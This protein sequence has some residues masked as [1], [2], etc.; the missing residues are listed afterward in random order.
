MVGLSDLPGG[1][2][3]SVAL[4]VTNDGAT[5]VGNST[6]AN[7]IEAFRWS[8]ATGIAALGDL[9]GGPFESSARSIASVNRAIV[10]Y[11]YSDLGQEAV[12]WMPSQ[13]IKSLRDVLTTGGV[14]LAGWHLQI[15]TGISAD[16]RVI[17]GTGINPS[18]KTE[19]WLA[20][21]VP[22]PTTL[23]ILQLAAMG[24]VARRRRV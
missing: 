12:I 9:P 17:V 19:A 13:G 10:G 15:A 4:D 8:Q 5:I 18:G 23:T 11:G 6:P 2:F 22:E 24:V 1:I 20:T 3:D 14:N 21:I 16:G 7:G